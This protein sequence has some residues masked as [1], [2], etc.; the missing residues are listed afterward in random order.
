MRQDFTRNIKYVYR[1]DNGIGIELFLFYFIIDMSILFLQLT[2][3]FKCLLPMSKMLK[4]FKGVVDL[5][6][7]IIECLYYLKGKKITQSAFICYY[8]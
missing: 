4:C 8:I 2:P 5:P 7:H 6:L 3:S 1:I